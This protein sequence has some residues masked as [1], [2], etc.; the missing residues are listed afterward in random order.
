MNVQVDIDI[1][2]GIGKMV[3]IMFCFQGGKRV[4]FKIE[5]KLKR[6]VGT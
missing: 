2:H 3:N 6:S 4:K 5:A 1:K